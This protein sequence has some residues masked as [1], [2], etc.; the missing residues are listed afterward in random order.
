NL[1]AMETALRRLPQPEKRL[2]ILQRAGTIHAFPP[3]Y[4]QV[5]GE[6]PGVT[7]AV[8]QRLT[9]CGNVPEALRLAHLIGAA[10]MRGESGR[11]A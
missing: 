2:K 6:T 11:S 9:D 7:A 1:S 4:F 3:F 10:V 8:L 5:C